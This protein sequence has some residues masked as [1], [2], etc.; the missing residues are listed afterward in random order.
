[1]PE[2]SRFYGVVI[3]MYHSDH[4]PPHFHAHYGDAEATID[5][6]QL[7]VSTG[8]LP[9]RALGMVVEWAAMH[10]TELLKLWHRAEQTESLNRIEPLK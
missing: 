9:P 6:R 10:Q 8:R 2:I 1:M 7:A 3:R 5:I 4:P